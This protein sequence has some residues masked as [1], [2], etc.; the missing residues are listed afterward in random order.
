MTARLRRFD[1]AKY[2]RSPDEEIETLTNAL[3]TGEAGTIAAAIGA[4]V[5][6]RGLGGIA[7]ETG[8]NRTALYES[9][10]ESGNPTLDT[11]MRILG[12]LDIHLVAT[13]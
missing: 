10:S 9:L 12:K 5:R 13:A 2:I 1:A 3:A 7:D 6:A 4:I 8:L 11:V